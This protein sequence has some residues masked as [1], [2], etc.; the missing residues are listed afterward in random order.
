MLG[1]AKLQFIQCRMDVTQL[2]LGNSRLHKLLT[3]YT[4]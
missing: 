1:I 3:M 2:Q 4:L